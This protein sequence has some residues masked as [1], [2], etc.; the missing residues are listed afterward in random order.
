L[1][2]EFVSESAAKGMAILKIHSHPGFYPRF[3]DVD[4]VSDGELFPSIHAWT[5]D[6]LPH[7][8]CV[9]LPDGSV[10]G[11]F[12][13]ANGTYMPIDRIAIAGDELQFF[14][15]VGSNRQSEDSEEQLRTRQ[16]F[17]AKTTKMLASLHIGIVGCSGTGSWVAEQLARLGVGKLVLVDPDFVERKNLNRIVATCAAD[18]DLHRLKVDAIAEHQATYGTCSTLVPIPRSVLE[19]NSIYALAACDVLFGCMDG[20]E[21]RDVLN[22][23]ATFYSIPYFDLGIQLRADGA[24]GVEIVCGSVHYLLPGG[25]SLLSRGVYTPQHLQAEALRRTDPGR[26]EREV[27]EGYIRGVAVGAPAVISIN[28]FCATLAVNEFLARLHPF[29]DASNRDY[30]WQQFDLVNSFIQ[31]RACD[32]PCAV[33]SKWTGRGDA[34][35]LLNCN[36]IPG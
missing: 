23:I 24:G 33:L 35:P 5:D 17:G 8:S 30:R 15:S 27:K 9:M 22:R 12:A 26:Y 34:K 28:G 6:G 16:T 18:A 13:L 36:L 21:G 2:R 32:E 4:D 25:S 20:T 7:A 3:S 31:G 14:D 29:R 10:F 11:R 19:P 1:I